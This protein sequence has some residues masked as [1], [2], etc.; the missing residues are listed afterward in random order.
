MGTPHFFGLPSLKLNHHMG[1]IG[2]QVRETNFDII[3]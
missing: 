2:G 1:I 3:L